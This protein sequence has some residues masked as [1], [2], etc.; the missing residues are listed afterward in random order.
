MF[1]SDVRRLR[2]FALLVAA[3]AVTNA[4]LA[5]VPEVLRIR[6]DSWMPFNGDPAGEKPGYV[7]ELLR[8]IFEPLGIRIDYQIMPWA[9]AV[10]AAEAAEIEG[11]IGANKK[12]AV[13]L[14]TGGESISE[15]KFALFTRATS[16]WKYESLRSLHEM[17]IGAIEG[18]TYWDGLDD[19]LKKA[20][21]PAVKLYSGDTPLIDAVADLSSGK[22]DVLVESVVVFYWAAKSMG[23]SATDFRMAYSQQSEPLYVAFAATAQGRKYARLFDQ[24]IRELKKNDRFEAILGKYGL[25]K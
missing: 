20:Q 4:S 12:E 7:V 16:S 14:V 1:P 5:A 23:R 13:N 22:T 9:G 21:P 18:Y 6:A 8:E 24:G 25:G 10:K 15:P 3:V 2:L 17:K 11:I 19:Y